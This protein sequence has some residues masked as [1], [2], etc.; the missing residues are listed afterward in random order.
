MKTIQNI[1]QMRLAL[2]NALDLVNN[3][4]SIFTRKLVHIFLICLLLI[5][6]GKQVKITNIIAY[7][8]FF[9]LRDVG[10]NMEK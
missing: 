1:K 4:V 9:Q 5:N 10:Q 6:S 2:K 3:C 8:G 7:H